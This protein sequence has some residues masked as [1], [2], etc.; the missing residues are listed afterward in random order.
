MLRQTLLLLNNIK[1][2][3]FLFVMCWV[4][5]IQ[6]CE[7]LFLEDSGLVRLFFNF[8]WRRGSSCSRQ[9]LAPCIAVEPHQEN[10][11][12]LATPVLPSSAV[13]SVE[14]TFDGPTVVSC[15]PSMLHR[16]LGNPP[17][18]LPKPAFSSYISSHQ[19]FILPQ[20]LWC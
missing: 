19:I 10:L 3:S 4:H 9:P 15:G 6:N 14:T 8:L 18:R 7:N 1:Y 16:V 11:L 17:V 20:V 5:L 12:A 13:M 2:C